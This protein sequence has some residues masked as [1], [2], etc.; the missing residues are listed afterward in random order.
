MN[1]DGNTAASAEQSHQ[2]SLLCRPL[3]AARE[4]GKGSVHPRA[5][6]GTNCSLFLQHLP[7]WDCWPGPP[8]C[9]AWSHLILQ[10]PG[11]EHQEP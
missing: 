2:H 8:R 11:E 6:K 10:I 3:P 4:T 9:L 5:S 7:A 1:L